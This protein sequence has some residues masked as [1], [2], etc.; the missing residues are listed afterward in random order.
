MT[1]PRIAITM[2]DPAGVGP[3][4]CLRLLAHEPTLSRCVPIIFG[5]AE[6]LAR[7]ARHCGFGK[8]PCVMRVDGVGSLFRDLDTSRIFNPIA[9]KTKAILIRARLLIFIPANTNQTMPLKN[10]RLK[11]MAIQLP[12]MPVTKRLVRIN[13][14]VAPT[15]SCA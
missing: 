4:V 12:W 11:I 9:K 5:D 1:L 8:I 2:G 10:S 3:E 6:V 14:I 13:R 7:A 15:N